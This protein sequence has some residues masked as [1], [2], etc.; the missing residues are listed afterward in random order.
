MAT[1]SPPPIPAGEYVPTADQRIVTFGVPWSHYE[2]QLALRGEGS[3]PRMAYLEGALELT[4]PS[5]EHE[6]AKSYIGC[7]VEAYALDRGID[8]SP[9]GAWTLESAR[10]QSG[11]EPDECY[12]VGPRRSRPYGHSARLFASNS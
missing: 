1:S 4:S 10:K 12:I 3:V 8:L 9:Y 2:A 7:L 6:R 5:K 11:V